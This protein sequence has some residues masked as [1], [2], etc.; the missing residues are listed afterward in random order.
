MW[1]VLDSG[2]LAPPIQGLAAD[3]SQSLS[4]SP[5]ALN[6]PKCMARSFTHAPSEQQA[7]A[8]YG[9][10][11]MREPIIIASRGFYTQAT[12]SLLRQYPFQSVLKKTAAETA[13]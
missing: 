6:A 4:A 7:S 9:L 3:E 1:F 10:G 13:K 12:N 11:G 2:A 5:L 8:L